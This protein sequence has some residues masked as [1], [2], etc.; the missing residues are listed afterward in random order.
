MWP[1][2]SSCEMSALGSST[3]YSKAAAQKSARAGA[4]VLSM[5]NFQPSGMRPVSRESN[6]PSSRRR[7]TVR[8]PTRAANQLVDMP[9]RQSSV[10]GTARRASHPVVG[11]SV[12]GWRSDDDLALLG[13]LLG[14]HATLAQSAVDETARSWRHPFR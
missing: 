10:N 2:A 12:W 13:Q 9:C 4:F 7:L 6:D 14:G 5:T 3:S 1:A 8:K 11:R